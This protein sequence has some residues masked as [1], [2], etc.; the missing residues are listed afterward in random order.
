VSQAGTLDQV[1]VRRLDLVRSWC[2][3]AVCSVLLAEALGEATPEL[4][5]LEGMGQSRVVEAELTARN[6][7]GLAGESP[8]GARVENPVAV[9]RKLA[10]DVAG[11]GGL[12]DVAG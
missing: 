12:S 9:A 5:D 11:A 1:R 4:R 6:D 8:E 7:L 10:P 2:A 3:P